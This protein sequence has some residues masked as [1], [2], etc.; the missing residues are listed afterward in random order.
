[1]APNS[2]GPPVEP[3]ARR[4]RARVRFLR[5]LEGFLMSFLRQLESF[6]CVFQ[7]LLGMLVPGL[8]ILFPVMYGGHTVRV[9]GKFVELGGSLVRVIWHSFSN[10][11]FLLHFRIIPFCKLS[12]FGH[13]YGA[14]AAKRKFTA[15]PRGKLKRWCAREESR[16]S[17]NTGGGY[18]V[19]VVLGQ[20]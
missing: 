14:A 3:A 19:C 17:C 9:R 16:S 13:S 7:R 8:V 2:N 11:R 12:T 20:Y 15:T 4:V 6:I 10:P 1:M 18:P 5:G